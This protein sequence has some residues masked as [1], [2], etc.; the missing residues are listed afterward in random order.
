MSSE[1]ERFDK[2]VKE[3]CRNCKK[4]FNY[5]MCMK[6]QCDECKQKNKC[7]KGE[8]NEIQ[9]QNRRNMDYNNS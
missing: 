3:Q 6:R 1:K 4:K 8:K 9:A 5:E 7:F 2:Y